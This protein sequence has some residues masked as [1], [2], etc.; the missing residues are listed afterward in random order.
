MRSGRIFLSTM[1]GVAAGTMVGMLFAPEKGSTIRK[2]I[3]HKGIEY[4]DHLKGK[5]DSYADTMNRKIDTLKDKTIDW[6]EKRKADV[7][8]APIEVDKGV[9]I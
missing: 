9:N 4:A 3:S 6:L 7:Q 1:A 2:N 5:V 8:G